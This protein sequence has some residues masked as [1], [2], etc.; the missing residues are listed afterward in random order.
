MFK[1]IIVTNNEADNR[2]LTPEEQ[3]ELDKQESRDR[4]RKGEDG[5]TADERDALRD[6]FYHRYY[7]E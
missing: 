4:E 2:Q 6:E 1:Q 7:K 5:L 3:R